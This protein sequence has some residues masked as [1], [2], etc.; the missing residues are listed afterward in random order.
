V[1]DSSAEHQSTNN[2]H[3]FF[4]KTLNILLSFKRLNKKH[5][6]IMYIVTAVH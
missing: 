2:D 5:S 6:I 4:L 3:L 1:N